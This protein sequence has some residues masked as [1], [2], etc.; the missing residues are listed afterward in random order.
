[1]DGVA[2][3]SVIV[4][5]AVGVTGASVPMLFSLSERHGGE[6]R[7]ILQKRA[8]AYLALVKSFADPERPELAPDI[9][10]C[11]SLYSSQEVWDLYTTLRQPTLGENERKQAQSEITLRAAYEVQETVLNNMRV[12]TPRGQRIGRMARLRVRMGTRRV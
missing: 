11:L 12:R 2:L 4:S 8:D 7:R 9:Q 6:R 1:M 5:G 10:A 3:A